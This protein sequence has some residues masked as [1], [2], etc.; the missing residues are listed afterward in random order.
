MLS[1]RSTRGHEPLGEL[2]F[3]DGEA[4]VDLETLRHLGPSGVVGARIV[5][6]QL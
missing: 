6:S 1:A 5:T 4:P 3:G 2:G